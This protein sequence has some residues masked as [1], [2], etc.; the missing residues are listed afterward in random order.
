MENAAE[1]VQESGIKM[2]T[3]DTG[4]EDSEAAQTV[5]QTEEPVTNMEAEQ[6]IG[7]TEEKDGAQQEPVK[8][9]A[10]TEL[11]AEKKIGEL[12][13][14][15]TVPINRQVSFD[16]MEEDDPVV[17][18]D[19]RVTDIGRWIKYV[20]EITREKDVLKRRPMFEQLLKHFP[21]SGRHWVMYLE[22]ERKEGNFDYVDTLFKRVLLTCNAVVLWEV[23]IRYMKQKYKLS[24]EEVA[25]TEESKVEGEAP[26]DVKAET[27]DTPAVAPPKV[28]RSEEM[29]M[30]LLT[31]Q[32][33]MKDNYEFALRYAGFH[34]RSIKIWREYLDYIHSIPAGSQFEKGEKAEW[35]RSVYVRAVV[36]PFHG[37]EQIWK[38]YEKFEQT[39]NKLKAP[40]MISE[41]SQAHSAAIAVLKERKSYWQGIV[42]GMLPEHYRGTKKEQDQLMKWLNLLLY[43]Q[44]N[45]E[46]LE[47]KVEFK[48][49]VRF[50]FT[51]AI[52]ALRYYPEI[53]YAFAQFELQNCDDY[54]SA[55]IVLQQ[56][57]KANPDC[58]YLGFSLCD[59]YEETNQPAKAKKTY[60]RL[61]KAMRRLELENRKAIQN[62]QNQE[63]QAGPNSVSS[64]STKAEVEE[65]GEDNAELVYIQYMRFLRRAEGKAAARAVF[66]H[67][68]VM[69]QRPVQFYIA[70]AWLEYQANKNS[71]E[72][73]R[74]FDL[75][76]KNLTSQPTEGRSKEEEVKQIEVN[77][78]CVEYVKFVLEINADDTIFTTLERVLTIM[79][80]NGAKE[81][82]RQRL[83][84]VW[85]KLRDFCVKIVNGGGDMKLLSRVEERIS[86]S[87]PTEAGLR[88]LFSVS[89]R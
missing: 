69:L 61:V 71:Q 18:V 79:E 12:S 77:T 84:W 49:R 66:E 55:S 45:P 21:H 35:L 6:A 60:R 42:Q 58:L 64:P 14:E 62:L 20:Q 67:G 30:K 47:D 46:H 33:K 70:A 2:E 53:W 27:S 34:F 17:A 68:R 88:T 50:L 4:I 57:L 15:L 80:E 89:H 26:G 9:K 76:L 63:A 52:A 73:S 48:A 29:A 38:E 43:E 65:K 85:E 13:L 86:K 32:Q 37:V 3:E 41:V 39:T 8:E 74:I 24:L 78:L 19:S 16:D 22:G 5:E 87:F 51:E 81:N 59:L 28:N 54:V 40:Q 75:G 36:I 44:T 23:Y 11:T 72:A 82:D 10:E 56:S 83:I 7:V 31:I 1:T 25:N